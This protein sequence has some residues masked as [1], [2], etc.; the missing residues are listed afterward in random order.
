[1]VVNGS[2]AAAEGVVTLDLPKGWTATPAEQPVTI[3][4]PRRVADRAVRRERRRRPLQP[5]SI[6]CERS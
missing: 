6:A 3:V 2:P 4:A 5:A 1:M